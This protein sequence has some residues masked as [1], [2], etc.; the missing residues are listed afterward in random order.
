SAAWARARPDV[1]HGLRQ[2]G[3]DLKR[4]LWISAAIMATG[5]G[6]AY[7]QEAPPAQESQAAETQDAGELEAEEEAQEEEGAI[8]VT[9]QAG[10]QVRIDRRTY[11]LQNDASA[12]TSPV[13]DALGRLPSVSV[14]PSGAIRLLGAENVTVQING[15]PVPEQAVEQALRSLMGGDVERIEVIT[16]PSAT[17]SAAGTGGIIN[18]ITKQRF[19][20]GL[21]GSIQAGVDTLGSYQLNIAPSYSRGPWTVGG[22]LGHNRGIGRNELDRERRF[23]SPSQT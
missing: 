5:A 22:R 19:N 10:D 3:K 20:G 18:I 1:R 12:Q 9:G 6:A 21:T 16:N 8:V 7:A 14:A 13:I 23:F 11:T 2:W 17:Q 4:I 15:Q